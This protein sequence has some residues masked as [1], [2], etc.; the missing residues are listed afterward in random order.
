M[1]VI[2][3]RVKSLIQDKYSKNR[4]VLQ[5]IILFIRSSYF[6]Q[7]EE[8]VK[9]HAESIKEVKR[10]LNSFQATDMNELL[11]FHRGVESHLE[12]LTDESQV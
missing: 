7:I 9:N 6:L 5:K 1:L 12:K 2:N 4:P 3:Y 8:D 11:K 10:D